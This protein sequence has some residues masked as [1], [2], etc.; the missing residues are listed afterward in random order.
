[1]SSDLTAGKGA[2]PWA[3][4]RQQEASGTHDQVVS[5][6]FAAGARTTRGSGTA[7]GSSSASL[8][9]TGSLNFDQAQDGQAPAIDSQGRVEL[10]RG[11]PGTRPRP[12]P[13][14]NNNVFASRFDNTG[15]ANQ[16][17]WIFAGQS[18]GPGG[19]NPVPCP[20]STFTPTRTRR[21]RRSPAARPRTRR[22]PVRGDLA[23]DRGQRTRRHQEPDLRGRLPWPQGL[24]TASA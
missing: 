4:F 1:M 12:V 23:G 2:V 21:T 14:S 10:S 8:L 5:R 18:R 9:F 19:S 20:R 15:D 16:G 13:D 24:L 3:V 17:E 11:R 22:S 7:G 6:S